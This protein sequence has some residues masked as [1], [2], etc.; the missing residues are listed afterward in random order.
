MYSRHLVQL[1][2]IYTPREVSGAM[3]GIGIA[4]VPPDVNQYYYHTSEG[5]QQHICTG[6]CRGLLAF[7]FRFGAH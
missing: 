4:H 2:P 7:P 5:D 1:V 3:G 6:F